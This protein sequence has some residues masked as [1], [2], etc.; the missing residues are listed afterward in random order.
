[1][2]ILRVYLLA[3]GRL[4]AEAHSKWTDAFLSVELWQLA[5]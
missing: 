3:Q 1:M 5:S 2:Q 4:A